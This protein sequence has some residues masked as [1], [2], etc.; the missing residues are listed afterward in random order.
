MKKYA[1]PFSPI[2]YNKYKYK[3]KTTLKPLQ[4]D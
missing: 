3:Y 2:S 4:L 1:G